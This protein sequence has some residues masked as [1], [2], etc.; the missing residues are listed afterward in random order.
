MPPVRLASSGR[1]LRRSMRMPMRVLMRLRPSA[2]ASSQALAMEVMSVTFG[3]SLT[4]TG[5]LTASLTARV[6]AA[7]ALGSVPKL[8]PPPWTLG[9]EI[10]TSSQPTCGQAS[11]FWQT[12]TY[13]SSEKPLI[14]AMTGL[15]KTVC[16]RG[17]SSAM[18]ASTPGFCR[19]TALSRPPAYSAIRGW[20]L[21]VRG[22]RVVPLNEKVPRQLMS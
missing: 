18:T 21:P 19:P 14:L 17:S 9:Q 12:S 15:W 20:A 5:F 8:M 22:A 13:S 7:A 3:E 1:L 10:L 16:S 6:T 4:M 2:P 11:S